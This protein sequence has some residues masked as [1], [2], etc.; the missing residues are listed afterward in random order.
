MAES[1]LNHFLYQKTIFQYLFLFADVVYVFYGAIQSLLWRLRSENQRKYDE[2]QQ[3]YVQVNEF[4]KLNKQ[5]TDAISMLLKL[6]Y[7]LFK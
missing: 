6:P 3:N 1:S 2:I 5:V 7:V 4:W